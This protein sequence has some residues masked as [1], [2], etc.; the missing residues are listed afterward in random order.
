M[1]GLPGEPG[2]HTLFLGQTSK[3]GVPRK[4]IFDAEP[5]SFLWEWTSRSLTYLKLLLDSV[6]CDEK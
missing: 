6:K 4:T 3:P 5:S 2:P 1:R